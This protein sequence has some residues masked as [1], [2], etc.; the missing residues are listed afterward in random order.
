MR[1]FKNNLK[2]RAVQSTEDKN[3]FLKCVDSDDYKLFVSEEYRDDR[4][5]IFV[6]EDNLNLIGMTVLNLSFEGNILIAR[7]VLIMTRKKSINT[8]NAIL[9][10][11]N[12]LFELEKVH[13]VEVNVYG[14]NKEM[15][16]IMNKGIFTYEGNLQFV[17]KING[18]WISMYFYSLLREEYEKYVD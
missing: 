6:F 15:L 4:D 13:R 16:Q 1:K 5:D 11:L 12:Y 10:L 3:F 2:M 7:P 17:K 14:N 8:F 9:L 18:V